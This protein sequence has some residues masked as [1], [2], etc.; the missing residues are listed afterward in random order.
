MRTLDRDQIRNRIRAVVSTSGGPAEVARRI[1]VPL[2]TL[3]D[4]LYRDH[5]PKAETLARLASLG[6]SVDW[7]LF[8]DARR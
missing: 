4:C 8:G 1:G 7:L 2:P 6:V 5:L 3:E